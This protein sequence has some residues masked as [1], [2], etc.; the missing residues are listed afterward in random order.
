MGYFV[1]TISGTSIDGLDLALVEI[2]TDSITV[3]HA[4]TVPYP[5]AL[6]SSLLDLTTKPLNDIVELGRSNAVLGNFIGEQITQFISTSGYSRSDIEAIGSHGQTIYHSPDSK[7]SFSFQIGDASRVATITGINTIADFRAADI[8]AG[9]QGAP[10]VP[11]LHSRIFHATHTDRIVVNVGG[12][13][14]VTFLP[15]EK[16]DTVIGF[17]TG[18]GNALLDAWMQSNFDRSYDHHGALANTGSINEKLLEQLLTDP[19]LLVAPPKSTGKEH[20]NLNYVRE[21]V[22]ASGIE[23]SPIDVLATLVEFTAVSLSRA[24]CNWCCESGEVIVCGG[25][26]LNKYLM[27]RLK[28]QLPNHVVCDSDTMGVNGDAVE[29][30]AFAYLAYLFVNEEIGNIP[31]VTGAHRGR[32]LG[33]LYPA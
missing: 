15:I 30:A 32:V 28:A 27:D 2:T 9:G 19:Y 11:I 4:I 25:G 10:L 6:R 22:E 7:F 29:A 8:A 24:I 20:F 18:P 1:G 5:N 21:H 26:R 23:M 13:A 17:D 33:C 31:S 16:S 12:I 3:K 14:N